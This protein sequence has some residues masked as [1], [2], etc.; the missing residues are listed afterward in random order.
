MPAR[1][2]LAPD[3]LAQSERCLCGR[4]AP[5]KTGN[6]QQ[7]HGCSHEDYRKPWLIRTLTIPLQQDVEEGVIRLPDRVGSLCLPAMNQVESGAVGL[8]SFMRQSQEPCGYLRTTS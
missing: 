2:P 5:R 4:W 8:F 3:R 1:I 6:S 7:Q